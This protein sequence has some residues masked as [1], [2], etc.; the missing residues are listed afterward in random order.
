MHVCVGHGFHKWFAESLFNWFA[1]S[2]WAENYL[3]AHPGDS[4]WQ[5]FTFSFIPS[6]LYFSKKP[7]K[8]ALG[9]GQNC[10]AKLCNGISFVLW[11]W[12]V[13]SWMSSLS[14]LWP[15]PIC[16]SQKHWAHFRRKK[17]TRFPKLNSDFNCT[18]A[19]FYTS[20]IHAGFIRT[21]CT[22]WSFSEIC[23]N[24]LSSG[25]PGAL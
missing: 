2:L 17:P 22:R 23:F 24:A 12:C 13:I 9:S 6:F 10:S 18:S 11:H 4:L 16:C 19:T 1:D 21:V 7:E 5:S 14:E 20:W 25:A 15:Q 3:H 8:V